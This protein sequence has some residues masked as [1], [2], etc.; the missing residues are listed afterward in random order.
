MSVKIVYLDVA[1]GASDDAEIV[2]SSQDAE[3]TPDLLIPGSS[4]SKNYITLE[5][6]LWVLDGT[7]EP[8]DGGNI[9][10]RSNALSGS[11]GMFANPP[12]IEVDFDN[13]YTSLGISLNFVGDAFCDS[14]NI[15][16]YQGNTLLDSKDFEPDSFSYFCE[17]TVT[18]YNK[19]VITI[20]KTSIPERRARIDRILFGLVRT[21][22]RDELR[23]GSVRLQQEIDHTG[24]TLPA[25]ALD[26][27]LSSK[28]DAEYIF[29]ARQPVSAY[30]DN[31]ILG[32][33]Y[34]TGSDRLAS[35]IYDVSCTDAIGVLDE[36]PFTDAYYSNKNAFDLAQEICAPFVVD[37]EASLKTKT[38]SG[39]IVGQTKRGALQQL[40]FAIG[41]IADTSGTEKIHIFTLDST[42]PTEIGEERTRTG[43][44]VKTDPIVTEVRVISHSYSTSGSGGTT[45]EIGGVTYYDTQVIHTKLNPDV[46]SSDKENVIEVSECT[47]I[48][49]S[50]VTEILNL[51]YDASMRRSIHK[52]KFRLYGELPGAYVKTITPWDSNVIGHYT[53]ASIV[54]SGFALSDAEVVGE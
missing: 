39:V 40:C 9:A 3:S 24:R 50:N 13:Q 45:V 49:P 32:A 5:H 48:S 37:M 28:D 42:N 11:D 19:I 1:P 12:V 23:T 10:F 47:L 16:W 54:L 15:K 4:N 25:N 21:F 2:T 33:F 53:K 17:N 38:V 6:N 22:Y 29:Q 44:S 7:F 30:D 52:L 20:Y 36:A 46:T 43:A 35:N 41:A 34:I 31:T 51:L 8:Y 27:T 14:L 26:W 18:A